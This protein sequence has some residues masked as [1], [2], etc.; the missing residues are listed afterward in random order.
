MYNSKVVT[1]RIIEI[2]DDHVVTLQGD[3]VST[4]HLKYYTMTNEELLSLP[5]AEAAMV[6]AAAAR[7]EEEEVTGVR[8]WLSRERNPLTSW[9]T[10]WK[11]SA[12][13]A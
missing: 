12:N 10:I 9:L 6:Q 4:Y 1:G 3:T 5:E 2:R 7:S 13:R 8:G 11:K